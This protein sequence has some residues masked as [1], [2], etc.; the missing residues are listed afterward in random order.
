MYRWENM[1][2]SNLAEKNLKQKRRMRFPSLILKW[3]FA[4]NSEGAELV[5]LL[6]GFQQRVL[7]YGNSKQRNQYMLWRTRLTSNEDISWASRIMNILQHKGEV[8]QHTVSHAIGITMTV[9]VATL[10]WQNERV[11][12]S[13]IKLWYK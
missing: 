6:D 12:S 7:C 10:C 4:I 9:R 1:T 3:N 8:L 2:N 13:R 11:V 5:P